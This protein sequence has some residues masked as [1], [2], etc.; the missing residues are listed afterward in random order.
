MLTHKRVEWGKKKWQWIKGYLNN[1]AQ[2]MGYYESLISKPLPICNEH[3]GQ[4]VLVDN[5][6]FEI[7]CSVFFLAYVYYDEVTSIENIFH[8]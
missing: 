7:W 4:N 5:L 3:L 2:G 8:E 1:K 6:F